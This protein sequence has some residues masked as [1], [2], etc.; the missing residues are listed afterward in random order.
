MATTLKDTLDELLVAEQAG[1]VDQVLVVAVINGRPSHQF[2]RTVEGSNTLYEL[3][4]Y[5]MSIRQ[6]AQSGE[7]K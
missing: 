5:L 7:P 2:M 3:T 4:E 1:T 6:K